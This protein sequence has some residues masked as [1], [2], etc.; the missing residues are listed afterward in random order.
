MEWGCPSNDPVRPYQKCIGRPASDCH[1]GDVNATTPLTGMLPQV[2]VVVT[3]PL[4]PRTARA[5]DLAVLFGLGFPANKG[6]LLW[7]AD[8]LGAERI[9][10]KLRSLDGMGDR[11]RPTPML[12]TL[13]KSGGRFYREPTSE[14]VAVSRTRE[15]PAVEASPW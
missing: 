9:L 13:A 4:A 2:R 3:I 11:S 8:A 12:A 10:G 15:I 7:W 6:G 14:V 1:A 5:I